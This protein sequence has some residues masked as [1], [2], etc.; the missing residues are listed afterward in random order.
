MAF[1]NDGQ[2]RHS[3]KPMLNDQIIGGVV[4]MVGIEKRL[5]NRDISHFQLQRIV[6]ADEERNRK[7]GKHSLSGSSPTDFHQPP[8]NGGVDFVGQAGP[9]FRI[10]ARRRKKR[11]EDRVK[12]HDANGNREDPETRND[13]QLLDQG[14]MGNRETQNCQPI[15]GN[16]D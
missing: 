13:G 15:S 16:R 1:G 6:P 11:E 8:I 9:R 2:R 3:G 7:P 10:A 12:R 4:G 5:A 14:N